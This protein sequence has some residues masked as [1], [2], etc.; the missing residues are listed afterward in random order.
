VRDLAAWIVHLAESRTDGTFDAIAPPVPFGTLLDDVAA[1]CGVAPRWRWAPRG[2]LEALG[3]AP[4]AGERSLPLWLP[5]PEYDG[6]MTHDAG[7]ALA[8]GL[9]PRPL[10]DTAR[11]T[12]A[13]LRS[14]PDATLTGLTT[15]EE[16]EVLAALR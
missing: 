16:A 1:G 11:D 15:D 2:R 14:E 9:A 6:M 3:V 10:A 4:W 8:A 7:P 12:L 5:R 13:W